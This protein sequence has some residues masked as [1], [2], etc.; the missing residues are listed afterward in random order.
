MLNSAPTCAAGTQRASLRVAILGTRG[1]P[2]RY[3]GFETFAE[4]LAV[5][6]VERGHRVT[7]YAESDGPPGPDTTHLGVCVRARRRP[8]WGPASVLAY[9]CACLLDARRG[10]D[11][12]YMLGYGA[13]WACWWPRVGGVPV[14]I[15]VD[16]LEWARSKWGRLARAYLRAMEWVATRTAT[17]LIAD[18]DAIAGRFRST[19]PRGAPC[20]FIAYGAD[21]VQPGGADPAL[22]SAWGLQPRRYLLV[23]ARPEPEN[24]LFEIIE[25]HRLCGGAHPLVIVGD[26]SGATDYQRRL[27]ALAG[28]RVRFLGAIYEDAPLRSLRLHAAAYLHGHSVGGTNPSLLEAMACGNWVIAHDNPFNREVARDAA[29]YFRTSAQLAGALARYTQ[30][31]TE[32][33][34]QR[35]QRA[36]DIVAGHYTWPRIVDAYEALMREQCAPGRLR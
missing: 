32:T 26:V 35:G 20:S 16:G 29:D 22:L 8:H 7:V 5:G 6:L 34:T 17:R 1:I 2:A 12:V 30:T 36:R 33:L 18:A 24:H 19:Y 3:G 31:G 28:D 15:N 9:D 27:L 23:V 21:P 11:L 13:A 10:Y 14:W 4:R 25:G